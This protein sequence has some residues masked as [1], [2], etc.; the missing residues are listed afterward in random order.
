MLGAFAQSDDA[1]DRETIRRMRNDPFGKSILET[2]EVKLGTEGNAEF[3]LDFL[4]QIEKNFQGEQKDD[5]NS[6]KD[7]RLQCEKDE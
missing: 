1:K 4:Y 7:I 5:D 3:L 2:L 6:I